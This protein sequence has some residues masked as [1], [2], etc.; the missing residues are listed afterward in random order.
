MSVS[1]A[2][3]LA[4][5][6]TGAGVE[7]PAADP[8]AASEPALRRAVIYHLIKR[9]DTLDAEE[10]VELYLGAFPSKT[11]RSFQLHNLK[12]SVGD[13]AADPALADILPQ[14][15]NV[16]L[17]PSLVGEI[18]MAARLMETKVIVARN[19]HLRGLRATAATV[20]VEIDRLLETRSRLESTPLFAGRNVVF[21]ASPET[22][23]D[24]RLAFGRDAS[25]HVLENQ[26][27]ELYRLLPGASDLDA[28]QFNWLVRRA[29]EVTFVFEG[30]SDGTSL[31][32]PQGTLSA[33]RLA[34][35][36][37]RR[38]ADLPAP[39]LVLDTCYG[40][41]F[42][43]KL[44]A[45]LHKEGGDAARPLVVVPEEFG[46]PRIREVFGAGLLRGELYG[47]AERPATAG[48]VL[49]SWTRRMTLYAGDADNR[50]M[51]VG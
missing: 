24:G 45:A 25:R 9:V 32:L 5:T 23:P 37:A 28:R 18:P 43:R 6:L 11:R 7:K 19:L 30:H 29:P 13:V 41:D 36:L 50:P 35:L 14:I 15:E 46:L 47:T 4:L 38:A 21:A 26:A 31:E 12:F 44:L 2:L 22:L 34:N 33:E 49:R 27:A 40:H 20:K 1:C 3:A 51:H 39:I 48:S 17:T 16:W 42:A 8:L 10:Q